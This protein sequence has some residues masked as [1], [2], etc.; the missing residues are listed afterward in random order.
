M[1]VI[2]HSHKSLVKY[3]YLFTKCVLYNIRRVLI[4]TLLQC[5]MLL[6]NSSTHTL[7]IVIDIPFMMKLLINIVLYVCLNYT[8][9]F[10]FSHSN[11]LFSENAINNYN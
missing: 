7:V 5:I 6:L 8:K 3:S 11:G 1:W 2:P 10:R 9:N 4:L